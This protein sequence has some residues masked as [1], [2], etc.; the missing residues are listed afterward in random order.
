MKSLKDINNQPGPDQVTTEDRAMHSDIKKLI[1]S[2]W[3]RD[4]LPAVK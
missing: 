4:E 3:N 1:K 2:I